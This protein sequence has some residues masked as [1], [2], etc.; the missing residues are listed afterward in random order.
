RVPAMVMNVLP[1]RLAIAGNDKVGEFIVQVS[2]AILRTRRH[3]RYRSEQLRRDLGLVGGPR[4]LHGALVNILPFALPVQLAGA[5]A[6]REILSSG[7]VD[8]LTFTFRGDPRIGLLL[9]TDSIPALYDKVDN[10]EHT[11]RLLGFVQR[12]LT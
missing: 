4:P 10:A 8:G 3:G 9:E 11:R 12:A 7:P 5:E 2:R 6:P 1:L